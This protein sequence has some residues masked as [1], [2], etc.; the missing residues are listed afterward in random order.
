MR[1]TGAIS[2]SC[3]AAAVLLARPQAAIAA[4]QARGRAPELELAFVGLLVLS[5]LFVVL[6]C[7]DR[8]RAERFCAWII[9]QAG[10]AVLAAVLV[11]RTAGGTWRTAVRVML[12]LTCASAVAGAV[13]HVRALGVQRR[14]RQ[15]QSMAQTL[16]RLEQLDQRLAE[17]TAGRSERFH[18]VYDREAARIEAIRK[19]GITA[20]WV[21]ARED[22]ERSRRLHAQ[23]RYLDYSEQAA[24]EQIGRLLEQ[25]EALLVHISPYLKC[26]Y[27]LN[28]WC[29]VHVCLFSAALAMLAVHQMTIIYY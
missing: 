1:R 27:L 15:S 28:L 5:G 14:L 23:V 22:T 9:L 29:D 6:T 8:R 25:R 11:P 24:F 16:A 21:R 13:L 4:A 10:V 12:Y 18:T 3:L 20:L 2:G 19:L 17:L 7:Y 26:D